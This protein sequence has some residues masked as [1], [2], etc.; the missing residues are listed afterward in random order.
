M[1]GD[2]AVTL[3]LA[4]IHL[5]AAVPKETR[6]KGKTTVVGAMDAE[7][8]AAVDPEER[9]KLFRRWIKDSGLRKSDFKHF[10]FQ[11]VKVLGGSPHR[12]GTVDLD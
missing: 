4:D 8:L 2:Y 12:I 10:D 5:L 1:E 7:V 9:L 3:P 6:P 11:E